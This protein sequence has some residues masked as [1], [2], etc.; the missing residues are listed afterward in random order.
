MN[1]ESTT[2]LIRELSQDLDAVRP[3]PS[4]RRALGLGVV[5][6]LALVTAA[7]AVIG[8]QSALWE[9]VATRPN[10]AALLVGLGVAAL[11]ATLATAASSVPGRD[12]AARA[13]LAIAVTALLLAGG[14]CLVSLTALG[15]DDATPAGANA[16][17]LRRAA[18]LSVVAAVP[19][20]AFSVRG[21]VARP[22]IGAVA[23]LVGAGA[24][25]SLTV[26]LS[27]SLA[28]PSHLLIGHASAPLLAALLAA[29]FVAWL[30]K[31]VAR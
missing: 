10:F 22:W 23:S 29:P 15:F 31:R 16:M 26:H 5:A 30:L 13:G 7:L 14:L 6:W 4:L 28:E 21:W 8:V 20:V 3:V 12:T 27:C 17:C 11:A 9:N 19:L 1:E 25:A 24:V 2:E 18:G